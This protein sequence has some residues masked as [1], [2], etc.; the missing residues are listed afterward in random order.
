MSSVK[1]HLK[2]L[3]N[4]SVLPPEIEDNL[5]DVSGQFLKTILPTAFY[6]TF[7]RD[8]MPDFLLSF[9]KENGMGK[10]L[11]VS[12]LIATI[13]TGPE[14]SISKFLMQGDTPAANMWTA[15]GEETADLSFTFLLKLLANDARQDDC[16]VSEPRFIREGVLLPELLKAALAEQEGISQDTAG[17]LTPRFTR[18]A[19]AAWLPISKRKKS[20]KADPSVVGQ[21]SS[22]RKRA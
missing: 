21:E 22:P 16:E 12:V 20:A 10:A 3:M 15:L 13:G 8:E 19:I 14:E 5:P 18:V 2:G 9:L 4:A 11:S 6:Q 17:H 1:R 7:S